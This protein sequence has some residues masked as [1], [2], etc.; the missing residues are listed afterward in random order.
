MTRVDVPT[1][2]LRGASEAAVRV[3]RER[4]SCRGI[5][6]RPREPK[7]DQMEPPRVFP[8]AEDEVARF[9]VAVD[10]ALLVDVL[11]DAQLWAVAVSVRPCFGLMH[12]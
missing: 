9:D 3:F 5:P 12:G 6:P 1:G 4:F 11:E 10:D 8:G 7:V 2:E